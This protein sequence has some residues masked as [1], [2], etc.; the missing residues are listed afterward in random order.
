[1]D[2][3]PDGTYA[4][5]D[6]KT[7]QVGRFQQELE[8]DLH[9]QHYL[10]T[11][12]EEALHP[13]RRIQAAGYLLLAEDGGYHSFPRGMSGEAYRRTY[14]E[15]IRLLLEWLE[16]EDRI[17]TWCPCFHVENHQLVLGDDETRDAAWKSCQYY[18]GYAAICA[19]L[20]EE[21]V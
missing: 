15:M 4:I 8:Q 16:D 18:C 12:A 13:E 3:R 21:L 1:M 19:Q 17:Q 14:G 9:L 6:Y 5:L 7:S 2:R 20:R 10:Y 11:L